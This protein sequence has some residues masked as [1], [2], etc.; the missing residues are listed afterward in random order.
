MQWHSECE[1]CVGT[2]VCKVGMPISECVS[3]GVEKGE[4]IIIHLNIS[5]KFDIQIT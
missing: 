2:G 1:Q 5:N 3:R 4:G